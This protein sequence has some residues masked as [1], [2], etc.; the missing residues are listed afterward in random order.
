VDHR[1]VLGPWFLVCKKIIEVNHR[2]K[3]IF[4]VVYEGFVPGANRHQQEVPV[5][6]LKWRNGAKYRIRWE[7]ARSIQN[8]KPARRFL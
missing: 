2:G 5:M 8:G 4:S 7:S 1:V 3:E 6:Y